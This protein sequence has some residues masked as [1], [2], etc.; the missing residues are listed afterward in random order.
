MGERHGQAYVAAGTHLRTHGHSVHAQDGG[1][2]GRPRVLQRNLQ[3]DMAAELGHA[4]KEG[5]ALGAQSEME[6]RLIISP[7]EVVRTFCRFI[8]GRPITFV[9]TVNIP[10]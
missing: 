4:L 2:K 3:N 1:G 6:R 7:T 5:S 10:L 9:N 8:L